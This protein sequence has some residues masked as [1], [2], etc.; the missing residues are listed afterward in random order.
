[1]QSFSSLLPL[2][3]AVKKLPLPTDQHVGNRA[4]MRRLMLGL[5]QTELA[6]AVG[7][8][9][10]QV[11]KYEKGKNRISA[12]RLQQMSKVLK[13]PIVFFFEHQRKNGK[14]SEVVV[15]APNQID[16]LLATRS[17]LALVRAFTQI[18]EPKLRRTIVNMVEEVAGRG[19]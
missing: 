7:V 18:K 6:T 5:S 9:F 8:T 13:V 3:G 4:R 2:E 17:G 12:S 15:N 19:D 11:Q 14:A 10:Q 1:L 16:A